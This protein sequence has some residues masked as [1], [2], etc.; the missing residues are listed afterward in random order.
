MSDPSVSSPEPPPDDT[1]VRGLAGERTDMAWSR[2]ALAA[3][4]AGAVILR[5]LWEHVNPNNG[6]IIVSSL[7][8]VGAVVWVIALTW[9]HSTARTTLEGR[10]VANKHAL[11]NVTVGTTIFCVAAL[12]LALLPDE[13]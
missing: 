10:R 2:S 8:G 5:R 12:I 7:L 9:A 1:D 3:S 11:R 4:V 6:R 13:N